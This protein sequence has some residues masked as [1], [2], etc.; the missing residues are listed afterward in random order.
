MVTLHFP[1]SYDFFQLIF[2]DMSQA[3]F[4]LKAFLS[5]QDLFT[6]PPTNTWHVFGW[7]NLVGWEGPSYFYMFLVGG[8]GGFG[9]DPK[10]NI[11]MISRMS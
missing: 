11:P 4:E 10:T 7:R 6:I 2:I 5:I 1:K 3:T 8:L 9:L